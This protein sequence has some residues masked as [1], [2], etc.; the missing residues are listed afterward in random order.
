MAKKIDDRVIIARLRGYASD[1]KSGGV[2]VFFLIVGGITML[3]A[4]IVETSAIRLAAWG[5]IWTGWNVLWS[6]GILI[7]RRTDY[8]VYREIQPPL[9]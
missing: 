7:G 3:L 9:D 6:I 5:A 8:I 1:Q 4:I 2:C